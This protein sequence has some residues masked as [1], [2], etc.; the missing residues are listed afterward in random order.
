MLE[1]FICGEKCANRLSLP[2]KLP[3]SVMSICC[4][5]VLGVLHDESLSGKAKSQ[6]GKLQVAQQLLN[7]RCPAYTAATLLEALSSVNGKV[8]TF[9]KPVIF[10]IQCRFIS[11][12]SH[13]QSVLS[14]LLPLLEHLLAQ[15]GPDTPS[16]LQSETQLLRLMLGKFN[17]A[18]APL[19]AEDEN[20][21]DL[22]VRA[23]TMDSCQI[24]ALEQVWG[25]RTL[26]MH[27]TQIQNSQFAET[28]EHPGFI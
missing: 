13:F 21:M 14:A 7:S 16:L 15:T 26:L 11:R 9:S 20:C 4:L 22:F 17:E 25:A 1:M 5:Q 12:C 28:K 18:S 2:F 6:Q 10:F 19:L 23:L 3:K 8:R 24:F 27:D